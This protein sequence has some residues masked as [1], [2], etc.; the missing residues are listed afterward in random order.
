MPE[1]EDLSVK[2]LEHG[3]EADYVICTHIID[4]A[5]VRYVDHPN[6]EMTSIGT[7]LCALSADIHDIEEL[8]LICH[9][10]AKEHGYIIEETVH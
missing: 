9:C 5:K 6:K 3:K 10:C 1:K 4:G 7:I 2:C 8:T